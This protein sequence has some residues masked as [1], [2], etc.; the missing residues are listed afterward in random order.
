MIVGV[1]GMETGREIIFSEGVS[2]FQMLE[3]LFA[4]SERNTT[5]KTEIMAGIT[6]FITMAYILFVAPGV[7]S[8]AG[9]DPNAVFI[10]TC[11]GGG[12]VTIAMGVFV[13]YP[14]CL[15]PGVGLLAFY[16]FTV[17]I[18]MQVPWQTA[19]GAVFIS[20]LVFFVLTVTHIRQMIIEGIPN[21]LK[22]AITVGIGLFICIIGLKMSGLMSVT[23]SLGPDVL[24]DVVAAGGHYTAGSNDTVFGLGSMMDPAHLVTIFG[25]FFTAILMSRNTPGAIIVGILVTTVVSYAVGVS[26]IPENFSPFHLP[27][28][29]NNA[30][31]DLDIAGA[32]QMGIVTIVFTFTFVELFDSMGTMVGA[33][34][35]AG[36]VNPK[37]GD[38]PGM[39]KALLC[40]ACGVSFGSLLGSSTITAF[41]ESVAGVGAGGRTG[42]TAV[43]CGVLFLLS[44]LLAPVMGLIPG[45][46][47]SQVLIL[48]GAL[49]LEGVKDIDFSDFTEVFPAFLTIVLMPFTYS[50]ANGI[51]GGFVAYAVLKLV[52]GKGR[53]VHPIVYILAILIAVRFVFLGE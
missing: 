16:A 9:M 38:F 45:T 31:F 4:L 43:T 15:A 2:E 52:T 10:A 47:T 20:G 24:K 53:E 41:V 39:G 12:L 29:S 17:C 48:V 11:L 44:L 26:H 8:A 25:L 30:F 27:D 32:F 46:A 35:K 34:T 50:I 23:L 6:T 40:D 49:M 14:I 5:V 13:N 37:T 36:L 28:F 7:L 19:L 21:S 1:S 42:L 33:A 22:S 18:G 3:K 51:C